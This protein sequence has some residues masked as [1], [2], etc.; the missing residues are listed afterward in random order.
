MVVFFNIAPYCKLIIKVLILNP[1]IS[2]KWWKFR[3]TGS[4]HF[5][6][7]CP[8]LCWL[9]LKMF[10][11]IQNLVQNSIID[12]KIIAHPKKMILYT[13][14]MMYIMNGSWNAYKKGLKFE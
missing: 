8:T 10:P 9:S 3:A 2:R 4:Y 1:V 5:D 6:C 13:I 14:S 12:T 7:L 11:I